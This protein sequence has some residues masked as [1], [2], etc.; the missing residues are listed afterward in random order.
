MPPS[1]MPSQ[2]HG[3][4]LKCH[5]ASFTKNIIYILS[6]YQ[7]SILFIAF[8]CYSSRTNCRWE[9]LELN[10]TDHSNLAIADIRL[11]N[12]GSLVVV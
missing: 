10:E 11:S 5:S 1:Y 9:S 2:R 4:I 3:S 8:V 7:F 12:D 6:V